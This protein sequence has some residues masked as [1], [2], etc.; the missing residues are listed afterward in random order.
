MAENPPVTGDIA[1]QNTATLLDSLT[2]S[3][4]KFT[5]EQRRLPKSLEEVVRAGYIARLPDPPGGKKLA[6][7]LKTVRVVLVDR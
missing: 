6:L 5:V 7:D 1:Q 4:R 3:V 2:Q